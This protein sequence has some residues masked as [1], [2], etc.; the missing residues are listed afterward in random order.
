MTKMSGAQALVE[1]LSA[2]GVDT[3]F[4]VLGSTLLPVYD[5]LYDHPR[6]RLIA[7]RGE[8]GALHMA[9]A[10]ARVSGKV[11]VG[12]ITVGA[13]AAFSVS[14]M[15][16]AYA[17]SWPVL[18]I[19]TQVPTPYLD[20]PK[21]IY[22]ECT[23]QMGLF[24]PVTGWTR[25]IMHVAEIPAVIYEAFYRMRNG[26]P[27]PVMLEIPSDVLRQEAEVTI[28]GPAPRSTPPVDR[29]AI[30]RAADL[31]SAAKRPV[32]W[33]GGG[34][35]KAEAGAELTA[36]AER[37]QAPVF[38]TNGSKGI[39]P[40]DHPFMFGNLLTQ[41]P[42]VEQDVL[43][44][45]DVMLALGT[46]FSERATRSTDKSA[47]LLDVT[48]RSAR[49]W[50]IKM[51]PTVIHADIDPGEFNRNVPTQ[52]PIHGDA[53]DVLQALLAEL[54]SRGFEAKKRVDEI[55]AVKRAAR[56]ALMKRVPAEIQLLE[57]LRAVLPRDG[58]VAAQS[59][60]GHWARYALDMYEPG[61]FL[62]ANTF[63]SMGFAFHAAIGAK[64]A[65]P[66]RPVVALCGDG[67]FLF[68]CGELATIAHYRL[69]IPVVV[70]NNG[71]YKILQNTQKK[72]YGRHIGTDL[73]SPDFVK[74]GE[75]FGFHAKRVT[76][77]ATLAPAIG[78]ALE[79]DRATLIEVP[80]EF[81][82]YR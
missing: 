35:V 38:S 51:P 48:G 26:R 82:P 59:I 24:R 78:E 69:N 77:L 19:V 49:G 42:L 74:L 47:A 9:D 29:A 4:G 50:T 72:R 79:R 80:V 46:R 52:L 23:D 70:F 16:E 27:R 21:G 22:H 60:A 34:V 3:V 75:S 54:K 66:G 55:H 11:G 65:Y 15:G 58:I 7:P 71:G 18:N 13:G 20:Q 6:I 45:A 25:R 41:S 40:D 39:V 73:T 14:A 8:D 37:L 63:G 1:S 30:A 67:G 36:L 5:A 2:Q 17:E 57:D 68:G 12:M 64:F 43:G 10:Y 56:E 31:L 62:F 53:K 81:Q 28:P 32:L 61:K 33:A 44:K 76:D